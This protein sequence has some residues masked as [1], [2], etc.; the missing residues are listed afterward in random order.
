MVIILHVLLFCV[1]SPIFREGAV[2]LSSYFLS[3]TYLLL[4]I[5]YRSLSEMILLS[6]FSPVALFSSWGPRPFRRPPSV[7]TSPGGRVWGEGGAGPHNECISMPY[8]LN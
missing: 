2:H 5:F 1:L 8:G 7:L 3:P 6:W 4:L